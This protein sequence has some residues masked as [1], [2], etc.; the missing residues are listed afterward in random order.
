M[1]KKINKKNEDELQEFLE[2]KKRGYYINSKKGKG[3]YN[4]KRIKREELK[5]ESY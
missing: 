3:S 4:R 2:F 1:D 5:N